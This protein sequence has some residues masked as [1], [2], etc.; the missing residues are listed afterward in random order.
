M[1]KCRQHGPSEESSNPA[2]QH[3]Q[4]RLIKIP[5]LKPTN[6]AETNILKIEDQE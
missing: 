4:Y 2:N 1:Y 3:Q 6:I 5:S